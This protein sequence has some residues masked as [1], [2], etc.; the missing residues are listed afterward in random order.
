MKVFSY[1][2]ETCKELTATRIE[3]LPE[4]SSA[5][6]TWIDADGLADVELI[7]ALGERFGLHALLLEDILNTEHLSLIHI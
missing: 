5:K 2:T 4:I 3:D 6:I 7:K 1:N